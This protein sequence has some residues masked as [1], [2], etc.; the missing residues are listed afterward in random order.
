MINKLWFFFICSGIIYSFLTG[1]IKIINEEIIK[2]TETSFDMICIIF[3]VMALW[4]GMMKIC[5]NSGL[6]NILSKKLSTVLKYIFPEIP[7][8]HES[9]GFISSNVIANIFGLGSAAT[10]FGLKAMKSLQ[11]LNKNK[12]EATNSMV[13]FLI[14]NTSGLTI[15]PT[16][17]ISLRMLYNSKNPSEIILACFL[18]TLTSTI[19]GLIFDKIFRRKNV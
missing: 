11:S 14:L 1:N 15:I 13:T 16:T 6:L 8:G 7:E 3:P 10:P 9:L 17:I 18:A 19:T 12:D 4:L 5:T 2:C